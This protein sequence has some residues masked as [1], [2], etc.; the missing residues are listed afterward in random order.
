MYHLRVNRNRN[1]LLLKQPWINEKHENN[2]YRDS[3]LIW[4]SLHVRKLYTLSQIWVNFAQIY[5]SNFTVC[6]L[7][8]TTDHHAGWFLTLFR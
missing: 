3:P 7:L 2:S 5:M 8:G 1:L 4:K 6:V